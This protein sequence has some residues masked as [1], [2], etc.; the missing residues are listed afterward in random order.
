VK[1]D[2]V[3]LRVDD[4]LACQHLAEAKADLEA[5]E[6]QLAQA[7]KLP[8]QHERKI[9]Q[10]RAAIEAMQGRAGAARAKH[11][12]GVELLKAE[13]IKKADLESLAKQVEEAEAGQRAE[14]AKLQELQLVDPNLQVKRTEADRDAKKA[15]LDQAQLAVDECVLRAP[16]DGWVLQVLVSPGTA[17]TAQPNQPAIQFWPASKKRIVRAE[18]EQ[19]FARRIEKGKP[20]TIEEESGGNKI[21]DGKVERLAKWYTQRRSP[22]DG[23]RIGKDDVHIL[24]CIVELAID[25]TSEAPRIGQR[26]RVRVR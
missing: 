14:E 13:Q 22:P 20:V 3:L 7:K 2:D 25:P 19:E 16:E 15:K 23:M 1:K 6:A 12:R 21:C 5:A 17:L 11:T 26:V 9:A 4:R 24:E 10:Q 18:V 8:E